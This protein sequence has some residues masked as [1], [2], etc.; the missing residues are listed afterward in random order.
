VVLTLMVAT[1]GMR[2]S[3]GK[4]P[5]K[6]WRTVSYPGS[7]TRYKRVIRA[8]VIKLFTPYSNPSTRY[9]VPRTRTV[10]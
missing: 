7:A 5:M 9:N 1:P 6:R 8:Q 10:L 3:E 2:A 4:H